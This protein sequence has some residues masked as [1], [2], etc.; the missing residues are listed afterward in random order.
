MRSAIRRSIR[1]PL[2]V[3]MCFWPAAMLTPFLQR[4]QAP[5]FTLP[6][7]RQDFLLATLL[8]FT[9]A[10]LIRRHFFGSSP[11]TPKFWPLERLDYLATFALALFIAWSVVSASWAIDSPA[12][13]YYAAKWVGLTLFFILV[14]LA[15]FQRTLLHL[16]IYSLG[17]VV[18]VVG[19]ICISDAWFNPLAELQQFAGFGEPQAM[20]A[21]LF[22]ALA[23]RL[24]RTRSSL[25][26]AATAALAWSG[27]LHMQQ[28][29]A[30]IGASVALFALV[31]GSIT[32]P[33]YRPR[34]RKRVLMVCAIFALATLLQAVP[35]RFL[36]ED[37]SPSVFAKTGSTL[38]LTSGGLSTDDNVS[39][40]L[41]L[42]SIAFEMWRANPMTGVG[43]NNFEAAY[44]ESRR[45]FVA[46]NPSSPLL[47]DREDML[48]K[49]AHNE[50]V[51]MLAE[52]GLPGLLLFLVFCLIL[53]TAAWR[54]VRSS[55][56]PLAL[57][58]TCSLIAFA[59]GSGASSASFR[60]FMSGLIFFFAAALVFRF[61]S[62]HVDETDVVPTTRPG[63]VW[64]NAAVLTMAVLALAFLAFTGRQVAVTS[65]RQAAQGATSEQSAQRLFGAA[66]RLHKGD[67]ETHFAYGMW[68]YTQRRYAEAVPHL[69]HAVARGFI[70]AGSYSILASAEAGSGNAEA[71]VA[72]MAA[73]ESIY[74]RSLY[75]RV[76]HAMALS[77]AQSE[78]RARHKF[79]EATEM[80]GRK[81]HGWWYILNCGR[82]CAS[83]AAREDPENIAI[84]S[85][86]TP[87]PIVEV[88]FLESE[89]R[90]MQHDLPRTTEISYAAAE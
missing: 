37:P 76:R 31:I 3:L 33:Q 55:R 38:T 71:A 22:A 6:F 89:V 4:T 12:A 7:L 26:C 8:A 21:P 47:N 70:D 24:R 81:A 17:F 14:F 25:L 62:S 20:A 53:A 72:T 77:E 18:C 16:S 30:L 79:A 9:F 82:R 65:L 87:L 75:V 56:N 50:Y 67:A 10:L 46:S 60:W 2:C 11:I 59:L 66:L 90:P 52:L 29:A 64:N 32:F 57:G 85:E 68:F 19:L 27:M 42:W 80:D 63:F 86:L 13:F 35:P 23:L 54:A 44:A 73:A 88:A 69:R 43:A 45:A 36:H 48:A 15:A 39:V 74:P 51:Q 41:L 1:H 5:V 28:R 58:A 34:N 78:A 49:R 83:R 40:R 84:A 61:A